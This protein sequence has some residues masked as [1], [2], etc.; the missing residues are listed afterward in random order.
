MDISFAL[1]TLSPIIEI[2]FN[3]KWKAIIKGVDIHA[4]KSDSK[5]AKMIQ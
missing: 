1:G 4:L 3:D 5:I 2:N